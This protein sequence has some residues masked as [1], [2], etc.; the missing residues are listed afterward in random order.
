MGLYVLISGGELCQCFSEWFD[1]RLHIASG[2]REFCNLPF[3][4]GD[5]FFFPAEDFVEE[6]GISGAEHSHLRGAQ[7]P[8][9]LRHILTPGDFDD[10]ICGECEEFF[11]GSSGEDTC[12]PGSRHRR[13]VPAKVRH[14]RDVESEFQERVEESEAPFSTADEGYAR[15]CHEDT[16][17]TGKNVTPRQGHM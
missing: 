17:Q 1:S 7:L 9:A 11:H 15:C 14:A 10:E 6:L 5:G 2:E 3:Q 4:L 12:A 16:S 13:G 8:D